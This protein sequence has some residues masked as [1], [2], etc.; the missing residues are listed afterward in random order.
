MNISET[1][2]TLAHDGM[3]PQN[4]P[5]DPVDRQVDRLDERL[6]AAQG[7]PPI[8]AICVDLFAA[9]GK[10]LRALACLIVSRAMGVK[11]AQA[12]ALAEVA[13]LAH[14]ATL[15]HD[16]VIDEADTRRGRPA[17]RVRWTNTLSVLGGDFLLLRSLE[18][19]ATL[20]GE[21][22]AA[23]HRHTLFELLEAEVAQH[24]SR[25]EGNLHPDDYIAIA[26][27]KTGALFAFACAA[28]AHL[29]D[30]PSSA[31]AL[32]AFGHDFGVAFQIADDV[33]DLTKGDP[34]K[35]S[36]LDLADGIFSF[37]LRLAAQRDAKLAQDL[38]STAIQR[39]PPEE[40][41]ALATRVLATGATKEAVSVA[42]AHV[43]RGRDVVDEL[44][45]HKE[46]HPI[47]ERCDELDDALDVMARA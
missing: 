32:D 9:G 23:A 13:E 37:P 28:P 5:P 1:L 29:L 45:F 15:L 46:L 22:L 10:R 31:A 35:P 8:D 47:L 39:L 27:G 14:G 17:A 30:D 2:L 16:D 33:R 36:F 12:I 34:S 43:R 11:D 7:P 44:P 19:V 21:S 6:R 4:L 3:S 42:R 20:G 40:L 25:H 18:V 24:L 38:R 26:S 41:Q